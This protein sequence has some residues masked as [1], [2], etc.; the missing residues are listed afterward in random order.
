MKFNTAIAALMTLQNEIE[1]LGSLT[2]EELS[3]VLRLLCPFAPH[4]C[5]ELWEQEGFEGLC[6]L[7]AWPEYDEEKTI[8]D[9]IDI[10]LQICGKF[11]GTIT[12][13]RLASKEEMLAAA[14]NDPKVAPLLEGK[15]IVKEIVVPGKLVNIVV[16]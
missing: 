6:S 9:T 3:V 5:E 13:Q 11:R 12:L 15:S 4:L 8:E 16:K 7:A 2:K 14:K 10:A 1:K